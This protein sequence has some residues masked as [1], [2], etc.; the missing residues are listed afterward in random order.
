MKWTT[1]V[2]VRTE[3]TFDRA[4]QPVNGNGNSQGPNSNSNNNQNNNNRKN[5]ENRENNRDNNRDNNR[6][7]DDNMPEPT[8]IGGYQGVISSMPPPG[9]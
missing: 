8:Y 2:H 5:D 7:G 6:N 1:I 4:I 3:I 9:M